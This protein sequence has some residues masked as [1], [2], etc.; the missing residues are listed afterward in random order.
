MR[1]R[2]LLV[3]TVIVLGGVAASRPA[4]AI[5]PFYNVFKTE[6]L[7]KHPDKRFAEEVGKASNRCFLCHQGKLRKHHNEF[8]KHLVP[9]LDKKEDLKNV[10]KISA[11]I[12]KVFA[13]HVDPKD[14]KSET[15]LDRWKAGKWPGGKLEDLK[16]E[17][18]DGEEEKE[19]K[20]EE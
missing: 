4:H 20:N 10:D 11:E 6:Y 9:L 16:K 18:K 1:Y 5:L 8:G 7:E 17:P 19:E 3:A 2:Y 13:M 12:K 15:Y 14:D